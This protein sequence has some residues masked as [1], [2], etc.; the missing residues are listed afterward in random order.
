MDSATGKISFKAV[1]PA[2]GATQAALYAREWF[3]TVPGAVKPV[4]EQADAASA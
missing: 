1:V 4:L 3:A 2:P